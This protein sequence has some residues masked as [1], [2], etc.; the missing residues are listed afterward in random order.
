MFVEQL[1]QQRNGVFGPNRQAGAF[2][3]GVDTAVESTADAVKAM[4]DVFEA[5][6]KQNVTDQELAEAKMRVAGGMVMKVQTIGQQ[7]DYRVEGILNDYPIDYYD[8]YPRKIDAVTAGQIQDV[9]N[10]Y[11]K[12]GEMV[13]VV[14][15]PAE[16]VKDQL[17]RVGEV[18][19][20]PMPAKREGAKDLGNNELL[21][22]AA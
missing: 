22:K 11:V 1:P 12:D 18:E 17:K 9:M 19:V 20:V 4:F 13:I 10:K 5:M 15:G 6:R 2:N 16:S 8:T 21:R 14:V 3:A 7:A